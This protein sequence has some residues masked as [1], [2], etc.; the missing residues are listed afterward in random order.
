[1]LPT[2]NV[3]KF[4]EYILNLVP[5][6]ITYSF[7]WSYRL[8][9]PALPAEWFGDDIGSVYWDSKVKQFNVQR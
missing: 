7:Y 2:S 5:I 4:L 3:M 9:L 6:T 8:F 1:M